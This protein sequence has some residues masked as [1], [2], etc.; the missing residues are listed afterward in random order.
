[1]PQVN[2]LLQDNKMVKMIAILI[3]SFKNYRFSKEEE[4][5]KGQT[6]WNFIRLELIGLTK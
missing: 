4:I 2:M 5:T 1:M 6:K 3:K